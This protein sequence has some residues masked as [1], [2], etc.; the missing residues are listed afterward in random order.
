M[1]EKT[2]LTWCNHVAHKDLALLNQTK[3]QNQTSLPWIEKYRPQCLTDVV[4][5]HE[6]IE[7]I[8][9]WLTCGDM[10]HVLFYGPPGTGK[11]STILAMAKEMYGSNYK[12]MIL[13]LNASDQRGIDVV[14]ED[15]KTFA[16]SKLLFASAQHKL[17]ILDEADSMT[18]GA[19]MALRRGNLFLFSTKLSNLCDFSVGVVFQKYTILFYCQLV[20]QN[21]SSFAFA[22]HA[23]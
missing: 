6:T 15:I 22:V 19:Q 12:K 14:R 16:T 23:I 5:Q 18:S 21:H 9:K 1:Q 4:S 20:G 11:T 10:P 13:E 7:T 2:G 3:E 8:R 17:I